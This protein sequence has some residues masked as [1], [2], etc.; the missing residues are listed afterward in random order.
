MATCLPATRFILRH[1]TFPL[2]FLGPLDDTD[3]ARS[4]FVTLE[5]ESSAADPDA[6]G[7]PLKATSSAAT[8]PWRSSFASVGHRN[9]GVAFVSTSRTPPWIWIKLDVAAHL[10][11][12][13]RRVRH[14]WH[15]RLPIMSVGK[16]F[17]STEDVCNRACVV[18]N[19]FASWGLQPSPKR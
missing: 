15:D 8:T 9:M 1:N 3:R 5:V 11:R 6:T 14:A 13:G 17:D 19:R 4:L 16:L 10:G 12:P 18:T 7:V 2:L